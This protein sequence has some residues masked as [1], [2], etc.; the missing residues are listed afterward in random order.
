MIRYA[1]IKFAVGL[2]LAAL[3]ALPSLVRAADG[4]I[5]VEVKSIA[6]GKYELLRGGKPFF[7]KGVGGGFSKQRLVEMGGNAVRTWG[8]PKPADLDEAHKLGLGVCVGIWL[9]NTPEAIDKALPTVQRTI[10][11]FKDHP[12]EI[13]RAHV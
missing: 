7:V 8:P 5:K 3:F 4:P 11:Q 9:G 1:S 10:T 2:A 12:A 13:G 6:E